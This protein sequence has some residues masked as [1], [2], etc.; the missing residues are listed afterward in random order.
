MREAPGS[1]PG[2]STF[3]LAMHK[4]LQTV[5]HSINF[6]QSL[7]GVHRVWRYPGTR[8][9]DPCHGWAL[10]RGPRSIMIGTTS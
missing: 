2:A 7:S 3:W 1:K 5:K 9:L 6:C 8:V 10:S 4:P